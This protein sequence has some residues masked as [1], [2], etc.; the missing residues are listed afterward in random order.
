MKNTKL[1]LVVVAAVF[2]LPGCIDQ[3][4][5]NHPPYEHNE[6]SPEE[7]LRLKKLADKAKM[8]YDAAKATAKKQAA[9]AQ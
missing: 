6:A 1:L 8:N 9:E 3:E 7:K 2:L 5:K 4:S